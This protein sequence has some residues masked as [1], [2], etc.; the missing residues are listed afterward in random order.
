MSKNL[1]ET[2][3]LQSEKRQEWIRE[4]KEER[5]QGIAEG[6]SS[7]LRLA[8]SSAASFR[9]R[10]ECLGTHCSL[11]IQEDRE[12]TVPTRSAREI[13]VKGKMEKR[14]E[15]DSDRRRREVADLLVLP[16]PAKSVQ[17]GAGFSKN[18][19][20]LGL[21]KRKER[22][23]RQK[24]VGKYARSTFAKRKR[25]RAAYPEYQIVRWERVKVSESRTLAREASGR[26]HG[27]Q[28]VDST[29]KEGRFQGEDWG[30]AI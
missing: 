10:N 25:N 15:R 26:E 22:L 9:G 28:R 17:N 20:I 16:R 11:I 14:T 29:V 12:K 5:L 3:R 6:T 24:A 18:L 21:Q 19:S 8:S 7:A 1:K 30:Q 27:E 2:V 23:Q 13:V 4:I